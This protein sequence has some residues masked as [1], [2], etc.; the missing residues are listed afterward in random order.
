M[1]VFSCLEVSCGGCGGGDG[2]SENVNDG[3]GDIGRVDGATGVANTN[4][5]NEVDDDSDKA[6][7]IAG[8]GRAIDALAARFFFDDGGFDCCCCSFSNFFLS[9]SLFFFM[10]RREASRRLAR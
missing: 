2:V 10:Q 3:V 1:M 8:D 5:A 4:D 6:G 7:D 9:F